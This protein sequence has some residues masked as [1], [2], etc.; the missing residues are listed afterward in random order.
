MNCEEKEALNCQAKEAPVIK[1]K[2]S[3][4]SGKIICS[5]VCAF[6]R[7]LYDIL[8]S[9]EGDEAET[10]A[11]G[12]LI[13]GLEGW[14][15]PNLDKIKFFRSYEA[16]YD[17][18][19]DLLT[20]KVSEAGT[21]SKEQRKKAIESLRREDEKLRVGGTIRIDGVNTLMGLALQADLGR[22]FRYT[23]DS[24]STLYPETHGFKRDLERAVQYE[25]LLLN[26]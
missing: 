12:E 26:I 3:T 4:G 25:M 20:F 22:I 1:Y 8:I 18:K 13:R 17:R 24:Y 21:L 16:V 7:D 14:D 2:I 19:P 6:S 11:I 15:D 5:E 9:R 23:G 10:I